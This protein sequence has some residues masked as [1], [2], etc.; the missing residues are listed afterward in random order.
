MSK[1]LVK[2]INTGKEFEFRLRAQNTRIGRTPA[3]NNLVLEDKGVSRQHAI[4]Q[5]SGTSYIL[6]DLKSANGTLVNG[7]KV[8]EFIL[9]DGDT[10]SICNYLLKF[11][12]QNEK[13]PID[14]EYDDRSLGSVILE[15]TPEQV[16]ADLPQKGSPS[17]SLTLDTTVTGAN[18]DT[19]L[20]NPI[21]PTPWLAHNNAGWAHHMLGNRRQAIYH[22]KMALMLKPVFCLGYYNLGLVLKKNRRYE[23]ARRRFEQV[24]R[25]CPKHA[26]TLLELGDMYVATAKHLKARNAFRTCV[27]LADGSLIGERCAQR[28]K[29]LP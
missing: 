15:R 10:I 26:P 20:K 6:I 3:E 1:L 11:S 22:L 19:L 2:E 25:Q 24:H 29:A 28:R 17:A 13:I 8:D 23:S 4:L 14:C 9:S 21:N 16:L 18:V 5:Q 12:D 27:D 7:K